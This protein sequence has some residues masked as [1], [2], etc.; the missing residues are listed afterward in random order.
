MAET[1]EKV[2][3]V[4]ALINSL[5]THEAKIGDVIEVDEKAAEILIEKGFAKKTGGPK[6][7]K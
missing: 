5:G 1:K 4:E 6:N 2:I 3:K 7:G